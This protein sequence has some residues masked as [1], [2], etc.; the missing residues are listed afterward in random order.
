MNFHTLNIWAILAAAISA[1]LVGGLWYS[2][3]VFGAAWKKANRFAAGE[4]PPAS[5]KIFAISF[6]LSLVMAF[7]L[8]MFLNDPKTNLA[9]GATAGFLAG[10]GWVT[11]AIGIVSLFER[12]PWTYVLVNGGYLTVSLVLMGAILGAWR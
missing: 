10:F 1:F 12:R 4:P 8:A 5:G 2:P 6:V 3:V 9:W 11:M 7:N